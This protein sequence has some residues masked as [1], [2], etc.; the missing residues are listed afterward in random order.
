MDFP[1]YY[2]SRCHRY[3]GFESGH[4][5]HCGKGMIVGS[6]G[7]SRIRCDYCGHY[8]SLKPCFTGV[9]FKA[10]IGFLKRISSCFMDRVRLRP[11]CPPAMPTPSAGEVA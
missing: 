3:G 9:L 1:F 4:C 8:V 11:K 7:Y 6:D 10:L 5:T 2:N